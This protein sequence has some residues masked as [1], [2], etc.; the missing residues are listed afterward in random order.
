MYA[1]TSVRKSPLEISELA[2]FDRNIEGDS[3][4]EMRRK[5]IAYIEQ[6]LDMVGYGKSMFQAMGCV[7]IP[8][9]IIP[10][11]WPVLLF[12]WYM[13]KRTF[14]MI[15]SQIDDALRYWNLDR[16]E[17]GLT[18]DSAINGESDSTETNNRW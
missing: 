13:R 6:A 11:F 16:N 15:D 1:G 17:L 12:M 9:M 10:V 8:F 3:E 18:P 5:R 2:A 4:D 7:M 14:G